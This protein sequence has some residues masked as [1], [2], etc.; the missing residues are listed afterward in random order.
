MSAPDFYFAPYF[1]GHCDHVCGA[2]AEAAGYVF[3]RR[4]GMSACRQRFVA[5]GPQAGEAR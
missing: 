1:C 4:G 2:M 5:R 3:E